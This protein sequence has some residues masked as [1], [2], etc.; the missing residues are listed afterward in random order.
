MKHTATYKTKTVEQND[1]REF[2]FGFFEEN[3]CDCNKCHH[4]CK[5]GEITFAGFGNG[6]S[7]ARLTCRQMKIKKVRVEAR[8]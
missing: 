3:I 6:K 2:N 4:K 1:K 7:K 5:K 8:S